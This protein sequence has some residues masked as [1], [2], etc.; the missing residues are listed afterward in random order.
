[1]NSI[2]KVEKKSS[3]MLN[4]QRM[5]QYAS[6]PMRHYGKKSALTFKEVLKRL[7]H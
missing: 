5:S 4:K 6:Y 3:Q 1:M 7:M 2:P